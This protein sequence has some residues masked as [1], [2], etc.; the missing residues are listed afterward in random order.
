MNA[1]STVPALCMY[2][3]TEGT[4][5]TQCMVRSITKIHSLAS[6]HPHALAAHH[7]ACAPPL[8]P[9]PS[10]TASP[11]SLFSLSLTLLLPKPSPP[12]N[13]SGTAYPDSIYP[14]PKFSNNTTH[15]SFFPRSSYLGSHFSILFSFAIFFLATVIFPIA[16]FILL[17]SLSLSTNNTL[18]KALSHQQL[19]SK[20]F[21]LFFIS[22]TSGELNYSSFIPPS[23]FAIFIPIVALASSAPV[24]CRVK[25]I[26]AFNRSLPCISLVASKSH[27]YIGAA[28]WRF[29]LA[30]SRC[31]RHLGQNLFLFITS[32]SPI[33][34]SANPF[35]ADNMPKEKSTTRKGGKERVV[36]RK[37]GRLLIIHPGAI[38]ASTLMPVLTP[39]RPQRPQAWTVRLHVLRQR[40]P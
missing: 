35:P 31:S 26:S 10:T 36:R 29:H 6:Q 4:V 3:H 28:G 5:L 34:H 27:Q 16:R 15:H 30:S 25:L 7:F 9:F 39:T 13:P 23:A 32:P 20:S 21:A 8:W 33:S 1:P 2:G 19:I 11:S 18:T 12:Y 37:K 38:D 40:H 22:Q 14:I 24:R 17:P